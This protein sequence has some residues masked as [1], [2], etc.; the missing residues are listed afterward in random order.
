MRNIAPPLLQ[1]FTGLGFLGI[2]VVGTLARDALKPIWGRLAAF[3]LVPLTLGLFLLSRAA[4]SRTLGA[5]S[6]LLVASGAS[7]LLAVAILAAALFLCARSR[8]VD[9]RA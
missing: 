9:G 5:A 7:L 3:S 8:S 4:G 1:I 6:E 2:L